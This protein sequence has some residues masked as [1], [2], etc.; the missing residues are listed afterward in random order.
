MLYCALDS[1]NPTGFWQ[2]NLGLAGVTYGQI[3]TM[4]Y[5]QVSV[6]DFLTLFR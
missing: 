1:N 6:T 5:L 2:Q 3:T 4:V